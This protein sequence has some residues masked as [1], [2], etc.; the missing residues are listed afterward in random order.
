[1][2]DLT[3][4]IYTERL[5]LRAWQDTDVATFTAINQD[6]QVTQ[7][8]GG[9]LI[10][11]QAQEFIDKANKHLEEYGFG[12]W[13]VELKETQQL[14]GFV[15][16]RKINFDLPFCPAVEIGWRIGSQYWSHGY[17]TEAAQ[18]ALE[19]GFINFSLSEIVSFTVP[20]NIKSI[21]VMEKLGMH[22]DLDGDLYHTALPKEHPLALH[23]LYRLSKEEY[24]NA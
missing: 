19:I 20:A 9:P 23:I 2:T 8:L 22:R 13:A 12:L 17:A 18:K 4:N 5:I 3:K 6:P 24:L 7:F 14:I 10:T 1:M 15:G 16:L 11:A 21:A